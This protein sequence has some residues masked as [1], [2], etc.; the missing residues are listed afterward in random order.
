MVVEVF[1]LSY[2]ATVFEYKISLEL[3]HVPTFLVIF[4]FFLVIIKTFHQ[5]FLRYTESQF[6]DDYPEF[7]MGYQGF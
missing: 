6:F 7:F 1:M 3:I 5:P 2:A 4:Q